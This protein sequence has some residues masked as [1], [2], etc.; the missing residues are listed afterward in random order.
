M[1]A[2]AYVGAGVIA[3]GRAPLSVAWPPGHRPRDLGLLVVECSGGDATAN[4][5]GWSHV[6]GS[7]LVDVASDAGSKFQ[8]LWRRATSSAEPSVALPD[9]GDHALACIV[10]IRGAPAGGSPFSAVTTAIKTSASGTTSLPAITTSAPNTLVLGLASRPNDSANA[11]FSLSN[12]ALTG[13]VEHLDIGTT[14]GDGGGFGV[15]SGIRATP[16]VVPG[17]SGSQTPATTNCCIS[18]AIPPG[19]RVSRCG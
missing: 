12:P 7:P 3:Q 16:G 5:A 4:L 18:L 15:W 1:P 9:L 11:S 10:V 6:S 17:S 19:R 13:F 2:P 8:L 14:Q